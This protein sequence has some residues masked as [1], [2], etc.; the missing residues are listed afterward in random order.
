[1][2]ISLSPAGVQNLDIKG[3]PHRSPEA[4]PGNSS[5]AAQPLTS[6]AAIARG[7][8]RYSEE[9]SIPKL[10][11]SSGPR[12]PLAATHPEPSTGALLPGTE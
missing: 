5:G 7:P 3:A 11:C 9:L 2:S 6:F 8:P 4:A 1:M 10:D 12:S